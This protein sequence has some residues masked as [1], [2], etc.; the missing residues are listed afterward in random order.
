MV[1]WVIT[2]AMTHSLHQRYNT[3]CFVRGERTP[4]I[5]PLDMLVWVGQKHLFRH[6]PS[7]SLYGIYGIALCYGTIPYI[8]YVRYIPYAACL[9]WMRLLKD[10]NENYHHTWVRYKIYIMYINGICIHRGLMKAF[11]IIYFIIKVV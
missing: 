6:V 8:R 2:M 5:Q 4:E 10:R 7:L 9:E 1:W 3:N 11:I